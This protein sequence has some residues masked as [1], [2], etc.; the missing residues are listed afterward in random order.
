MLEKDLLNVML[1][2][3]PHLVDDIWVISMIQA[4]VHVCGLAA[5]GL[6]LALV[7]SGS[8]FVACPTE[9][10]PDI[11]L[12]PRVNVGRNMVFSGSDGFCRLCGV[13]RR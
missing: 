11:P 5:G 4:V 12:L 3:Y 7:D 9:Y 6:E 2:R 13:E 10:A 8:G 1:Q